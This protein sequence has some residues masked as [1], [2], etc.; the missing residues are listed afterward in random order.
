MSTPNDETIAAYSCYECAGISD[1]RKKDQ[2]LCQFCGSERMTLID[3][4]KPNIC[5][6]CK[7]RAF[8]NAGCELMWD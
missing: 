2:P 6:E 1:I 5:P 8:V 7:E 4:D 3:Y